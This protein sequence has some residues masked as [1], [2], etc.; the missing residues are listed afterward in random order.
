MCDLHHLRFGAEVQTTGRACFDASRLEPLA[1]T[2]RTQRAFIDFLCLRVE[3][4]NIVR[5]PGN[6]I[7]TADAVVLLKIDDAVFVFD[8]RAIRWTRAQATG[9]RAMHA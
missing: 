6:A 4:W 8:N 3:F 7:A 2:V 1:H 9:I 5:A